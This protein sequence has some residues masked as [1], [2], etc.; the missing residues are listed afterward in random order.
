MKHQNRNPLHMNRP[1]ISDGNGSAPHIRKYR[2]RLNMTRPDT[3][4]IPDIIRSGLRLLRY[5][6]QDRMIIGI[7]TRIPIIL[8]T[9]I[10]VLSESK[11]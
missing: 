8:A 2:I 9:M 10:M 6:N 4:N 7:H 3:P 5:C 11:S 1:G